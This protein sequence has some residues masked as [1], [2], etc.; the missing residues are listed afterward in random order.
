M[1]VKQF[2]FEEEKKHIYSINSITQ[3]KHRNNFLYTYIG[4]QHDY[5][6]NKQLASR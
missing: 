3:M 1:H 5:E 2:I 4:L 6:I